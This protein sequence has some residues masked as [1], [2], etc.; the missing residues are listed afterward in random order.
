MPSLV[1]PARL[2][3]AAQTIAGILA[4]GILVGVV[5]EHRWFVCGEPLIPVR[6]KLYTFGVAC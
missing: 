4:L 1:L 2:L 3:R 5:G 6:H